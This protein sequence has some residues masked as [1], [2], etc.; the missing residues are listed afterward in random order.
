MIR[1]C[2]FAL[3]ILTTFSAT[4]QADSLIANQS[5]EVAIVD[6]SPSGETEVRY[7][8]ADEVAPGAELRYVLKFAN[9]ADQSADNVRLV[10]PVP[11]EIKLIEGSAATA[12]A[13]VTYSA[14]NGTTFSPRSD[15]TVSENGELRPAST[16]HITHIQWI[17]ANAIAPG[18]AGELSYSGILQ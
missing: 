3:S 7:V 16:E 13:N 4:A 9:Q 8:P 11:E 12:L 5:V 2:L 1:S 15:L 14:D 18:E 17:F 10:M 6:Q